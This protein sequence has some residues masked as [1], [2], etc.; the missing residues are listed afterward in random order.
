MLLPNV[1]LA[2][3]AWVLGL[4]RADLPGGVSRYRTVHHLALAPALTIRATGVC[5][6]SSARA[7]LL[8]IDVAPMTDLYDQ[9]ETLFVID[10]VYDPIVPLTHAILLEP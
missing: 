8:T 6:V 9:H 2:F 7:T 10:A 4:S 3:D 5:E 1:P